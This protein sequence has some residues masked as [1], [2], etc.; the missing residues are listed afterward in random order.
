MSVTTADAYIDWPTHN[1]LMPPLNGPHPL[2]K[3]C[4]TIGRSWIRGNQV[5]SAIASMISGV[6]KM[7]NTRP[8]KIV[9]Q[10]PGRRASATPAMPPINTAITVAPKAAMN[11]L[12]MASPIPAKSKILAYQLVMRPLITNARTTTL[13][14]SHDEVRDPR[15]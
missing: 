13:V 4:P 11:E 8:M 5:A 14:I 15:S 6:T 1:L 10:R 12:R 7:R 3:M 9:A 2:V